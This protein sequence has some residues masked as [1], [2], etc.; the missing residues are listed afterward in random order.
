[1][2]ASGMYP[3][4]GP[5][6]YE[7]RFVI[8]GVH[9][10]YETS[11]C[12]K[13]MQR[14]NI[15]KG[16]PMNAEKIPICSPLILAPRW[17]WYRHSVERGLVN[18]MRHSDENDTLIQSI[19]NLWNPPPTGLWKWLQTMARQV[20]RCNMNEHRSTHHLPSEDILRNGIVLLYD[21]KDAKT[22]HLLNARELRTTLEYHFQSSNLTVVHV[23]HMADFSIC[24][25]ATLWGSSSVVIMPHGGAT[26][27]S[28]YMKPGSRVVE[29]FCGN[30]KT[31]QPTISSNPYAT[32]MGINYTVLREPSCYGNVK[33]YMW[34]QGYNITLRLVLNQLI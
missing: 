13:V 3:V 28:I 7:T 11:Y 4:T 2:L 9:G 32:L 5:H 33:F 16:P 25:Q 27:H 19:H 23:S 10:Q 21:R 17:S 12:F 1:M 20:S 30:E 31:T 8:N 24:E 18:A 26:A 6:P 14:L 22:R 15:I 29:L 34:L